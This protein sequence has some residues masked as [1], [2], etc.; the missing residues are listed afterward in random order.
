ML[1]RA[2][3][4]LAVAALAVVCEG[5]AAP[6]EVARETPHG[7]R[8]AALATPLDEPKFAAAPAGGAPH[9]KLTDIEL[10]GGYVMERAGR[11]L[12]SMPFGMFS[13]HP[14]ALLG[15]PAPDPEVLRFKE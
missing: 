7:R 3:L 9:R 2:A 5:L 14:D 8:L 15:G 6:R 12:F 4:L 1:A 11:E 13:T 10:L